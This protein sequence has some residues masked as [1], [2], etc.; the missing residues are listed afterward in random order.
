M[1]NC[2]NCKYEK[3][4]VCWRFPPQV[5]PLQGQNQLTG[6]MEMQVIALPVQ[7]Q[8][9]NWCGEHAEKDKKLHIAN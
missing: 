4:G 9:D 3:E 8:P 6:Q 5:F 1:K 7:A 2:S